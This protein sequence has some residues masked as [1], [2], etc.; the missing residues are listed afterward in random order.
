[1]KQSG[2]EK[3]RTWSLFGLT[4]ANAGLF[5]GSLPRTWEFLTT[6]TNQPS[7]LPVPESLI[8][9]ST[10]AANVLQLHQWSFVITN[11]LEQNALLIDQSAKIAMFLGALQ[12]AILAKPY[13]KKT[14]NYQQITSF[15]KR[16]SIRNLFLPDRDR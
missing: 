15:R 3:S 11:V 2:K 7:V 4:L 16:E 12:L 14:D 13:F 9:I 6:I 8:R 1:M 5:M 10:E